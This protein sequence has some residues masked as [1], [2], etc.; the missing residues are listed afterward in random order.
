M[1]FT[2]VCCFQVTLSQCKSAISLPVQH[3][4][5]AGA[6][7]ARTTHFLGSQHQFL[8][9]SD[10]Y[11]CLSFVILLEEW[12]GRLWNVSIQETMTA[13]GKREKGTK[14]LQSWMR[15]ADTSKDSFWKANNELEMFWS[16]SKRW[17]DT[18]C[19]YWRYVW[20]LEKLS[21][22]LRWS[23]YQ[24]NGFENYFPEKVIA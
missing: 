20:S 24:T 17:L 3:L 2:T 10:I 15:V 1:A 4:H 9:N 6:T 7:S 14:K 12:Q 19:K 5:V 8:R 21:V 22:R 23:I 18:N 11:L 16:G 13:K